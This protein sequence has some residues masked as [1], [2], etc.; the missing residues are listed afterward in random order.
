MVNLILQFVACARADSIRVSTAEVMD[1]LEQVPLV[2]VLDERQF[3]AVLRANFAK[4][5][6]EQWRF[7]HLYHLFFHELQVNHAAIDAWRREAA[8]RLTEERRPDLLRREK[9]RDKG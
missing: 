2:D 6:R 7:D 9:N 1:C 4:S 8:Y 5:R 3:N